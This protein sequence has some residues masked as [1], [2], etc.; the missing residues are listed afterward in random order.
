MAFKYKLAE[1]KPHPEEADILRK[2]LN[3]WNEEW[4]KKQSELSQDLQDKI[5]G[6]AK[7]ALSKKKCYECKTIKK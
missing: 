2:E 5:K 7:E 1:S 6:I 4:D 3:K